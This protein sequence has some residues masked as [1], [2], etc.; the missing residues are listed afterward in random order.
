[1]SSDKMKGLDLLDLIWEVEEITTT[2]DIIKPM[3]GG[4]VACGDGP[5]GCGSV[6]LPSRTIVFTC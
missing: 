2:D 6:N 4:P 5:C 3:N 1:M